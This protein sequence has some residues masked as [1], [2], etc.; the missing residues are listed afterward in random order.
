MRGQ[1]ELHAVFG[2]H[3]M[4]PVQR[5]QVVGHV[6]VR[7]VDHRGAAVQDV[8]AAEQQIVFFQHQAQVVGRMAGRVDHLQGM[9]DF[10][11]WR[12]SCKR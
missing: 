3:R 4:K 6:A 8:I 11:L 1:D 9:G 7:R 2:A 5:I 10:T 12:L